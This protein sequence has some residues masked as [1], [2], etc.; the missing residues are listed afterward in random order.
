MKRL[1]LISSFLVLA[2]PAAPAAVAQPQCDTPFEVIV[3]LRPP[4]FTF[5]TVWDATY[6][7]KEVMTQL[8]AGVG[9]NAGTVMTY[10]RRLAKKDYR[11]LEIV[12]AEINRRG[13][14]MKE[15]AT[16]AKEGE[17]PVA[18]IR[19]KDRFLTVSNIQAGRNR[20]QKHVRVSWYDNNGLYKRDMTISDPAYDYEALSLAPAV[21]GSGFV[22]TLHAIGRKDVT[23]EH[24]VLMRYNAEGK[25][26]WR[27]AYR[28]GIPNMLT[29]VSPSGDDGYIATG[30]IRVDDGRMAGWILELA[31]DGTIL[32]QRIYPRGLSSV[33]NAAAPSARRSAD[34]IPYYVVTGQAIP[35]DKKPAAAWVMEISPVGEPQWQRYFRRDDYS[36][37]GQGLYAYPDG[38]IAFVANATAL[39]DAPESHHVKLIT[40]SSRG[41][42]IQDESYS[43]GLDSRAQAVFLTVNKEMAAV[44]AVHID[45]A[46]G[47]EGE[48]FG[49][50]VPAA[51]SAP[52]PAPELPVQQ[53]WIFVAPGLDVYN[54]PCIVPAAP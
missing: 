23:D 46:A 51:P 37:E 9:L 4:S 2:L 48:A 21:E 53:G 42:M 25:L 49:P 1:F 47:E 10:G 54:D 50:P 30:R 38:R 17:V 31:Y 19:M 12:V 33:L 28:P 13:R 27:R 32:W 7:G 24:G 44:G 22:V 43:E 40:L 20:E 52:P 15:N 29:G 8:A 14:A 35:A 34:G 5:P 16:P 3:T 11:P 26:V 36:F 18:M 6:G 45:P 39:E 41:Q